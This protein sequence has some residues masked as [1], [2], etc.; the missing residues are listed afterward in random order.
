M[1]VLSVSACLS[2]SA[3]LCLSLSACLCLPIYPSILVSVCLSVSLCVLST[4][5]F[6]QRKEYGY[7]YFFLVNSNKLLFIE[8]LSTAT[9]R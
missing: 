2:L 9:V 8:K 3:C 1:C 5:S 6:D 7:P 4:P